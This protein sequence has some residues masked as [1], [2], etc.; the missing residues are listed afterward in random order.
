VFK[1]DA[2]VKGIEC[3]LEV[4]VHDV[5]VI[6]VDLGVLQHHDDGGESVVDVALVSE[7]VMLVA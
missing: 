7:S 3:A 2:V 5:D 6:F 4:R 1:H